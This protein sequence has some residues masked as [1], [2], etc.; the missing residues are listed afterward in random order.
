MGIL[1]ST[2][3]IVMVRMAP[4]STIAYRTTAACADPVTDSSFSRARRASDT[5]A[6]VA[7]TRNA[8]AADVATIE[9]ARCPGSNRLSRWRPAT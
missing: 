8:T 6:T 3:V 7:K 5:T 1:S 2:S 9:L 4:S